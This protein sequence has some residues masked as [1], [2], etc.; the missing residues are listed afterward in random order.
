MKP[1]PMPAL[2]V[3]VYLAKRNGRKR[4]VGMPQLDVV[5]PTLGAKTN[6]ITP[7]AITTMP[8][9]K[10]HRSMPTQP[11]RVPLAAM[12]SWAMFGS[13]RRVGSR[14]MRGLRAF[15]TG[16]TPKRILTESTAC[17][18]AAVGQPLVDAACELSELVS[19]RRPPDFGRVSLCSECC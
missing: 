1:K 12:T 4:R 8:P 16:V 6:P 9:D 2:L 19:S 7:A 5:S 3:S 13:G 11:G 14:V 18:K 10:Q 17:S 15:P